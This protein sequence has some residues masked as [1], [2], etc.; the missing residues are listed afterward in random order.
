[1][2]TNNN[3]MASSGNDTTSKRIRTPS[4]H[5]VLL[6][7]GGGINGHDGNKVFREWVRVRKEDYNLAG[8]KAEKA[9]VA[10]EVMDLVHREGGRFLQRVNAPG[11]AGWWVEVDEPRALAKTS[12]ALREGAPQ[13]RAAHKDDKKPSRSRS[14]SAKRRKSLTSSRKAA[15]KGG[16]TGSSLGTMAPPP[17][18]PP[19]MK[20]NTVASMS[21]PQTVPSVSPTGGDN[22]QLTGSPA[23][24]KEV[25]GGPAFDSYPPM[26]RPRTQFNPVSVTVPY[27]DGSAETP[28][29]T[30]TPSTPSDVPSLELSSASV[31]KVAPTGIKNLR[32]NNS[33][34]MSDMSLQDGGDE[35]I[36]F[37]NPF[38]DE[39]AVLENEEPECEGNTE[40]DTEV[41]AENT[42]AE[43]TKQNTE[44]KVSVPPR[45]GPL[46]NV[47]SDEGREDYRSM[48]ELYDFPTHP[49]GDFNEEVK[50]VLGGGVAD[51]KEMPTLFIPWRGGILKRRYSKNNLSP[52][53]RSKASGKALNERQ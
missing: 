45:S 34:A 8:T 38:L 33:L 29:L 43:E 42:N 4:T 20:P 48:A 50:T 36:D 17:P 21:W 14:T 12:Q 25:E 7:R 18:Q 32:R 2:N 1:M 35:D 26:K 6:G 11:T 37:V 13:I 51:G 16:G 46:R 5:D 52:S 30:P 49:V 23:V 19:K 44:N 27:V 10:H 28:P 53:S 24:R 39:S 3:S 31:G 40:V 47:S 41:N 15:S 9:R 22:P